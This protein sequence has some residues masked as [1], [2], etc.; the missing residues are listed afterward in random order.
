MSIVN[1]RIEA[2]KPQ[3]AAID[4]KS[5]KLPP[6]ALNNSRDLDVDLK[7]EEQGFFGSF[8]QG[9]NQKTPANK[10]RNALMTAVWTS[11]LLYNI[12]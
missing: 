11:L 6:G 2:A 1:Q 10:A 4:P 3:P 8:W 12:T 5:G 9:G 7:K